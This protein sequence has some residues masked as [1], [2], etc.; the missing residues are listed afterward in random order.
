[1]NCSQ[2]F[3]CVKWIFSPSVSPIQMISLRCP[4]WLFFFPMCCVCVFVY[5]QYRH[6]FLFI[7]VHSFDFVIV[8]DIQALQAQTVYTN[9]CIVIVIGLFNN[10]QRC[11]TSK[12][13]PN[14]LKTMN[15][16]ESAL[17]DLMWVR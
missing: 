14:E 17:V 1:M 8:L 13:D 9:K 10:V 2:Y 3:L 16:M 5:A 6:S 7:I 12:D 11:N 4:F 15:E